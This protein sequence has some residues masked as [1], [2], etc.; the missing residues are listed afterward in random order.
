MTAGNTPPECHYEELTDF[1]WTEKAFKMIASGEL[2]GLVIN[3]GIVRARVWGQCPRCRHLL[4]DDQAL[5]AVMNVPGGWNSRGT[6]IPKQPG[7][8]AGEPRY[9]DVD[10]TCSCG[11]SHPGAPKGTKGCG[12]SFRLELLEQTGDGIQLG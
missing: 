2:H 8:Q 7:S 4:D 10:V 11:Y 5:T 1:E 12:V 3:D 6:V 9:R